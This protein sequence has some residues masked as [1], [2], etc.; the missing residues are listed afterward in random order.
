MLAGGGP[1]GEE[2]ETRLK[3]VRATRNARPRRNVRLW[4]QGHGDQRWSEQGDQD[5]GALGRW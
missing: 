4:C 1:P 3:G 2:Q 5:G